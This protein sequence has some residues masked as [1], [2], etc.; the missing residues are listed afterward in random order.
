MGRVSWPTHLK[1]QPSHAGTLHTRGIILLRQGKAAA[2]DSAAMA[3]RPQRAALHQSLAADAPALPAG[4]VRVKCL[5]YNDLSHAYLPAKRP[6]GA[7][8]RRFHASNRRFAT[9]KRR[10]EAS[11]RRSRVFETTIGSSETP[12]GSFNT[13]I[14]GFKTSTCGL[15][16]DDSKLQDDDSK[17]QTID[18]MLQKHAKTALCK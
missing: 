10:F 9:S 11:K 7:Q 14:P 4:L 1:T 13:T 12:I 5:Q 16:H 18:S 2:R 17:L 3:H 15:Q 6:E 8:Y